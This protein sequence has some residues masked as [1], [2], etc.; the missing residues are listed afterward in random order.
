MPMET[1]LPTLS[2]GYSRKISLN[3]IICLD[4]MISF[5]LICSFVVANQSNFS[6]SYVRF[7][8]GYE[9][10]GKLFNKQTESEPLSSHKSG[11]GVR[12]DIQSRPWPKFI[13]QLW[14]SYLAKM[15]FSHRF[16]TST[17]VGCV[18]HRLPEIQLKEISFCSL[19]AL[20]I[21]KFI[22]LSLR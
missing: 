15:I 4:K 14:V 2:A 3:H 22:K 10:E 21:W 8:V 7:W 5:K 18:D 16:Q 6:N 1:I 20:S 13:M 9:Q 12:H 11:N 19:A 17:L